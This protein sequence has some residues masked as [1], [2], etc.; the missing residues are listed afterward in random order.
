MI[1]ATR[2]DE[3]I[4]DD[5]GGEHLPTTKFGNAALG[6]EMDAADDPWLAHGAELS[7]ACSLCG[8]R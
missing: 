1:E 2:D 7:D 4:G 5:G 8:S 6:G 3:S